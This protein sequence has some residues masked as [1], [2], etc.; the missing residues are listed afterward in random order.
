M[1]RP[2][3]PRAPRLRPVL[4][5]RRLAHS[6][7]VSLAPAFGRYSPPL[8]RG[9]KMAA[10]AAGP[11][12]P[13]PPGRALS[14]AAHAR[15]CLEHT[16]PPARSILTRDARTTPLLPLLL[17]VPVPPRVSGGSQVP[18]AGNISSFV[19]MWGREAYP[20]PGTPSIL[21]WVAGKAA[22]GSSN[23]WLASPPLD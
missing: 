6:S 1:T 3:T 19:L 17:F 9:N 7:L 21:R 5:P 16:P 20:F 14:V 10:A 13:P 18:E 12:P 15:T 4:S 23:R 8:C 2:E 22:W 11:Q